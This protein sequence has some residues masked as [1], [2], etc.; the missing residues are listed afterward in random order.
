MDELTTRRL[1][2]SVGNQRI[3]T[4]FV[5]INGDAEKVL[6]RYGCRELARV[7]DISIAAIP[8]DKLGELSLCKQVTK[9][10][11]GKRCSVQMERS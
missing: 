3:L 6:H 2:R 7:G 9:I 4:A 1:T 11:S 8:L 10:E 5:R